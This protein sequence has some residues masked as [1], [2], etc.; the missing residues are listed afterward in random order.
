MKDNPL[1]SIVTVVKN[2]AASL[3]RT[4]LSV[5]SQSYKNIEYIIID[6]GSMDGTLDIV[7]KYENLITCWRSGPDAGIYDAMNKGI[8]L[9]TGEL[10]GLLNADDYY[11]PDAVKKVVEKYNESP[12]SQVL[13][14]NCFVVSR[15]DIG[16]ESRASFNNLWRG[17][18]P[19]SHQAM[20][21]HRE[22]YRWPQGR[23]YNAR[24][25][26]AADYEFIIDAFVRLN[27]FVFVDAILVNYNDIGLSAQNQ[28]PSMLE[29]RSILRK[30]LPF[31]SR[32]SL[33]NMMLIGKSMA[34]AVAA[35]TIRIL[36]G[37][38]ILLRMSKWYAKTFIAVE[39]KVILNKCDYNRIK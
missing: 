21:V 2:G 10:I 29:S 37:E 13:Y 4:I 32:G 31:F 36:L 9:C 7:K 15:L 18:M 23:L 12:G 3:E 39:S 6:G 14:G 20:F 19:F 34:L 35:K 5:L 11:E 30:Y 33:L 17:L 26:F 1:V 38:A 24:L 8:S 27:K 28:I 25:K 22:L 16:Y